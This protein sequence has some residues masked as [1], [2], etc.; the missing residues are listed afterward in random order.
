MKEHLE[1]LE[2]G[3]SDLKAERARLEEAA[4]DREAKETSARLEANREI[5]QLWQQV[6]NPHPT[7]FHLLIPNLPPRLFHSIS[8][9]GNQSLHGRWMKLQR[10]GLWLGPPPFRPV[11]PLKCDFRS[12]K[13]SRRGM[14][15]GQRPTIFGRLWRPPSWFS[16][17]TLFPPSVVSHLLVPLP[18]ISCLPPPLINHAPFSSP[19][20][21][22]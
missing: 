8:G 21:F 16:F 20:P 2:A 17:P 15:R 22:L 3:I 7:S 4:D 18:L 1:K 11:T 19:L 9:H 10:N 5:Q 6:V 13:S 12:V 14:L